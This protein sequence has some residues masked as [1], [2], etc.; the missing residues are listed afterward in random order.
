MSGG[1][2]GDEAV[3]EFHEHLG[4]A[5]FGAVE[6]AGESV[7]GLGL[8]DELLGLVVGEAAGVGEAGEVFAV[9][10][11]ILDGVFGAYEDDDGVAAFFGLADVD[12]FD[13]RGFFGEGSVVADYVGVVGEFFGLADVVAEDFFW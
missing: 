9:G 5:E 13:A 12:D 7:D 6:A 4:W 2:F 10:V 3:G 11:E 8:G 1:V